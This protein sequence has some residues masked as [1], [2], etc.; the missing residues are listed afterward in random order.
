MTRVLPSRRVSSA[1][2]R[3]LL[4]LWAPVWARSSRLRYRRSAAGRRGSREPP[5][6]GRR[7]ASR[8]DR[9]GQAVGA[10]ERRSG[11]P[12]NRA[13][14]SRSSAQNARVV[15]ERVVGRLELLE[16]RRRA[17]RARTGRRSRAPS[18]SGRRRPPRAARRGPAS[19]R[20]RRWAVVGGRARRASTNRATRSGSLRGR[21]PG[22]ARR[23]DAATPRRRR[24]PGSRAGPRPTFA[25]SRPPASVTGTSRA[26]AAASATSARVPVPP[27]CG[28][29]AVSRRIR[30][31]AGVEEAPGRVDRRPRR[32][33]ASA[34]AATWSAFQA[35]RPG[36]AIGGGG[37]SPL[38]WIASGSI[39]GD[40]RARARSAGR[41]AVTSDDLRAR[42]G[43]R[44]RSARGA[45]S[46]AASS[47]A[48]SRGVPGAKLSPMASAPA[49]TA[50]STPRCVGD[51]ADLHERPARDVGRVVRVRGRRRRTRG[52]RPRGRRDASSA[53]P[54]SARVEPE[55]PASGRRSRCRGRRTRRR[56]AGR[57]GRARAGGRPAPGPR[58]A[59]AG[60]GC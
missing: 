57:P 53:S 24:P 17:S 41:S 39:A 5:S 47:S 19:A 4:I 1:W 2:P 49:R 31:D 33:C 9:V 6:R 52:P 18:P 26:T 45:A 13:S 56:R 23:L 15:A 25:G 46:V 42:A 22:V 29:P 37:S 36:R 51:A 54:T 10:V 50:A 58:R 3:A 40:D 38:S 7:A 44:R 60:R 34:A 8:S 32:R 11:R 30:V 35:G 27:G 21:S 28:P 12:A 55:S 59:S 48:S 20:R 16:R 43:R 14:S